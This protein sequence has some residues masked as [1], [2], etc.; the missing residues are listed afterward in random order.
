MTTRAAAPIANADDIRA[1]SWLVARIRPEWDRKGIES[2]LTKHPE[3]ALD[4]LAAQ[5]IN[6][7]TTRGDQRTPACLG[8]DGEHTNRAR[9]SLLAPVSVTAKMPG[10]AQLEPECGYPGC[11]VRRDRHLAHVIPAEIPAHVWEQPRPVTR[12]STEQIRAAHAAA[13]TPPKE[14]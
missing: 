4:L 14:S 3:Q 13:F 2:A 11:G 9:T 12:A 10:Y 7:A 8:L 6:A 1:I 5:A